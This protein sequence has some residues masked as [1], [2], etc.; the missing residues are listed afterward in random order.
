MSSSPPTWRSIALQP[1]IVALLLLSELA[2]IASIIALWILSGFYAGFIKVGSRGSGLGIFSAQ[3]KLDHGQSLLW[4]TLPTLVLTLYRIFREAVI[5]ALVVETPFIELHKSAT[6]RTKVRKSVYVDYRTSFSIVAWYKALQNR[7]TFLGLCMLFSFV[8]SLALVP[9]AGGLFTEGEEMLASNSTVN[10]LSAFDSSV[11][12]SILDYSRLLDAVSASWINTAPYPAGTDGYFPLPR[13]EPTTSHE[14]YTISSTTETSQLSL[15]CRIIDDATL[16]SEAKTANILEISFTANDRDCAISG[17]ILLTFAKNPNLDY[18]KAISELE[19]PSSAGRTRVILFYVKAS[20]LGG[21][22]SSI[23]VSCIPSY[24]M[25]SG[26]VSVIGV[27]GFSDR[28][29]QT[30]SF[31]ERSRMVKELPDQKRGQFEQGV[32]DL[33]IINVGSEVNSAGRLAELVARYIDSKN[34]EFTGSVLTEALSTIYAAIYTMLCVDRFYPTLAQPIQQDGILRIPENRLHVV[35][36]VAITMLIIF[37]LLIV[38]TVYLIVYL[39]RHPSILAEEPIGLVGAANLL[40]NSNIP[41]LVAKFHDEPESDGRLRKP[42]LQANTTR[43]NSKIEYTDD[44]LLDRD[45]WVERETVSGRFKIVVEP[46][47]GTDEIVEPL[48]GHAMSE[49]RRP[50]AP[51]PYT[52]QHITRKPIPTP[53]SSKGFSPPDV[54]QADEAH[55]IA[56]QSAPVQRSTIA[57]RVPPH[58]GRQPQIR[59]VRN[60][61]TQPWSSTRG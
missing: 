55:G 60:E 4:T 6:Q 58:N 15:D 49:P 36:P 41:S 28:R 8:V 33:L 19:C 20:S 43:R 50:P 39:E 42:I 24:W 48:H 9:L 34:L 37:A 51:Q 14:N 32:T 45:C 54:V 23:L 11:D 5:A 10:V 1:V 18:L 52:Q 44:P 29:I 27:T 35:V 61:V 12:I 38:E 16:T 59:E 3:G 56:S 2:L 57:Q 46:E 40:H 25:V 31:E 26:T 47:A 17:D 30:P 53:A 21:L 7:H 22:Q 13:I